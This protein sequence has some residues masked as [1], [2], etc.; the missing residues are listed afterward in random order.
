MIVVFR[1]FAGTSYS[2]AFGIFGYAP[3]VVGPV[4]AVAAALSYL[5]RRR[6]LA[7]LFHRHAG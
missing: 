3:L 2:S 5:K 4:A 6:S 1:S 7:A